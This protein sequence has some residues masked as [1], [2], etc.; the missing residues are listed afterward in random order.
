MKLLNTFEIKL[1]RPQC[2]GPGVSNP[3][4]V[5]A[6]IAF[7]CIADDIGANFSFFSIA[8]LTAAL[9]LF[10]AIQIE[11]DR[12]RQGGIW[13]SEILP[14]TVGGANYCY[15]VAHWHHV[16]IRKFKDVD[17]QKRS[18]RSWKS[19]QE[20]K[21]HNSGYLEETK[22]KSRFGSIYRHGI[23]S[24]VKGEDGKSNY[25]PPSRS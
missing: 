13:I 18:Y 23:N 9:I 21:H 12:I 10:S 19:C 3:A 20:N 4:D 24:D 6:R 5:F 16:L 22:E 17:N 14:C 2:A 15:V 11:F 1:N 25:F 7:W 8:A